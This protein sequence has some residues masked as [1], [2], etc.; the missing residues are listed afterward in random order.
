MPRIKGLLLVNLAGLCA[1]AA[2]SF[3]G[4]SA[5]TVS[6]QVDSNA[7]A[8]LELPP[9]QLPPG[10]PRKVEAVLRYIDEHDSA[11]PGFVGGRE[12]TNDGRNNEQVL[13]RVDADGDAIEYRE[14]DVNRRIPGRNRGTE[15]LVTGSDGSAY[16]T[17]NHYKTFTTIRGQEPDSRGLR[18]AESIASELPGIVQLPAATAAKVN[19]V[20][21]YIRVHG[22]AMPGYVGGRDYHNSGQGGGQV[23]PRV[24]AD[25]AAIH[26]REWDVNPRIPGKNRGTERLVT[27]SDGSAYYTNDH[28][29][30]FQRIG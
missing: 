29:Q 7:R 22:T 8:A 24:D 4:Y 25:G 11:P 2:W 12:F 13:P 18:E 19:A 9:V 10:V 1:L 14:W 16:Y 27:G 15:R 21:A 17:G 26:Y 6:G 30:T 23:L 3:G 20:L 28:Y 5:R